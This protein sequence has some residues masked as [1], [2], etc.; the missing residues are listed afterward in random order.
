MSSPQLPQVLLD[1]QRML[2]SAQPP[3]EDTVVTGLRAQRDSGEAAQEGAAGGWV[4]PI[5]LLTSLLEPL[6]LSGVD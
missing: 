4:L 3:S 5:V 1:T 6:D 2:L